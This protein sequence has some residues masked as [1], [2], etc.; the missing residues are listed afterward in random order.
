[1]LHLTRPAC[2]ILANRGSKVT[3]PK[4]VRGRA[5]WAVAM[6]A[7]T[8]GIAFVIVQYAG[9]PVPATSSTIDESTA[10]DPTETIYQIKEYKLIVPRARWMGKVDNEEIRTLLPNRSCL[11]DQN[12]WAKVWHAVRGNE[13]V[14]AVDFTRETIL[15]ASSTGGNAIHLQVTLNDHGDVWTTYQKT[16]MPRKGFGYCFQVYDRTGFRTCKQCGS[17]LPW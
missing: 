16:L 8:F 1:M 13:P 3:L 2:S 15:A 4:M 12:T 10:V 7:V 11:T 14:P 5:L 9:K 17:Q 6:S